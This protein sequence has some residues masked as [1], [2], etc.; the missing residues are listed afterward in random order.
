MAEFAFPKITSI[1]SKYCAKHCQYL[2]SR[3]NSMRFN[4]GSGLRLRNVS[5]L[6][7]IRLIRAFYLW[8]LLVIDICTVA[9]RDFTY[10]YEMCD[11]D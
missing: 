2:S 7:N 9:T 11:Y 3:F 1:V 10:L 6:Q 8:R 5:C 4:K